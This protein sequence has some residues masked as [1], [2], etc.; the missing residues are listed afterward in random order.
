MRAWLPLHVAVLGM[1]VRKL[2]SP[3]EAQAKRVNKL[4]PA[5]ALP[6]GGASGA[7]ALTG[8]VPSPGGASAGSGSLYSPTGPPTASALAAV[9][10]AGSAGSAFAVSPA[11][12]AA[13]ASDMTLHQRLERVRQAVAR[14]DA[15]PDAEVVVFVSKMFPVPIESL[16]ERSYI[17]GLHGAGPSPA[18][19]VPAALRATPDSAWWGMDP[20]AVGAAPAG[21][22]LDLR[23]VALKG[24]GRLHRRG[25]SDAAAHAGGDRSVDDGSDLSATE[26][27]IGFARVFSGVLRPGEGP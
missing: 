7:G 12:A 27:F 9:S 22:K 1:V 19:V 8:A 18:A 20:A 10:S 4:W 13:L 24:S 16:P 3:V 23:G 11:A 26:T 15:S 5:V 25:G 17:E 2:P 6:P 21:S 14:C